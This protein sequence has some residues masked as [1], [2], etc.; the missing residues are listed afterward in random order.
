MF[1]RLAAV[2]LCMMA[3]AGVLGGCAIPGE[4]SSAPETPAA[5]TQTAWSPASIAPPEELPVGLSGEAVPAKAPEAGSCE[6]C[7]CEGAAD[8]VCACGTCAPEGCVCD[9]CAG[10]ADYVDDAVP[11]CCAGGDSW[12]GNPLDAGKDAA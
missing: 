6:P 12:S 2:L 1:L 4:Q 5:V 7:T 8:G 10:A 11:D 3:V 9:G